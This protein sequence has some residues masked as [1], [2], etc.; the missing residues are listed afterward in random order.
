MSTAKYFL[1]SVVEAAPT[2]QNQHV[3]LD[4]FSIVLEAEIIPTAPYIQQ[5]KCLDFDIRDLKLMAPHRVVRNRGDHT[6]PPCVE[7][8]FT[9]R[10]PN[11]SNLVSYREAR[12]AFVCQYLKNRVTEHNRKRLSE[13]YRMISET[14]VEYIP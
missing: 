9:F 7:Y 10:Y 3:V 14:T 5:I 8:V 12:K 13:T 1:D 6:T 2:T 11:I 4:H